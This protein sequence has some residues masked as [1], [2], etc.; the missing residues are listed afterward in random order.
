MPESTMFAGFLICFG[1]FCVRIRGEIFPSLIT[2]NASM[3]ET[4][5]IL[6]EWLFKVLKF[7]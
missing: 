4:F 5:N 1:L 2:T 6:I 7:Q 3:G